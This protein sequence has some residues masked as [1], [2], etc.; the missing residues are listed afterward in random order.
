[1][2]CGR[3][4]CVLLPALLCASPVRATELEPAR[5]LSASESQYVVRNGDSFASIG[6]RFG[7]EPLVLAQV[8]RLNPK[9]RLQPG[10][11]IWVDNRHIV[12]DGIKDGIVINIPQ[13]MLF[14]FNSGVLTAAYPVAL[15]R[16]TWR[17]PQGDFTVVET[18]AD[19]IW[20]VPK[21]IQREMARHGKEV[22]TK[23]APGPDNPL[24]GY[25]IGLSMPALGIH[26]T[27]APR[28]IYRFRSH[29]CIRLHP[30]DAAKL[31]PMVTVGTPVRII[32]EPVLLAHLDDGRIF[33]EANPD[34]YGLAPH[35][36]D[37]LQT[38]AVSSHISN[39]IDWRRVRE[40]LERKDGL[41]REVTSH[42]A[43]PILRTSSLSPIL[44]P[45]FWIPHRE[46]ASTPSRPTRLR[47]V[48]GR[49][50]GWLSGCAAR[51]RG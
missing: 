21:S 9:A 12:P 18:R 1:M 6:S 24:G 8:N 42:V 47:S 5:A 44:S 36:V 49:S 29:G 7:V 22:K 25:W 39:M 16:P 34:I 23:V 31:F 35:A 11:N 10:S 38:L 14:F 48:P 45:A 15:G 19:P 13:R 46:R 40:G 28:S 32:Y 2:R 27:T 41:A 37:D 33:L 26:G 4:L 20:T 50:G 17:T 51:C 3:Y 43:T 30:A